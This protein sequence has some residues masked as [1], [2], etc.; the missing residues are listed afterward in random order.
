M[1][2]ETILNSKIVRWFFVGVIAAADYFC[3]WDKI[4]L[5]RPSWPGTSYVAQTF[6]KLWILLS[7]LLKF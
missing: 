7:Q 3:F 6:L 5:H 4:L 1:V 2:L